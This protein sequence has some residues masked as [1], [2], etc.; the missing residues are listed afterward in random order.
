MK[1]II[2]NISQRV[3]IRGFYLKEI[4]MEFLLKTRRITTATINTK[5]Q[6][7]MEDQADKKYTETTTKEKSIN[8]HKN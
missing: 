8:E 1:E 2:E 7:Q 6:D 3:S 5:I 4:M